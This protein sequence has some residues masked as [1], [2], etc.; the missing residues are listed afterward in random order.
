M[1]IGDWLFQ[2]LGI[3]FNYRPLSESENMILTLAFL[4]KV[5]ASDDD[6]DPEEIAEILKIARGNYERPIEEGLKTLVEASELSRKL[7]F[8]E[9]IEKA[10]DN[11]SLPQ[12]QEFLELVLEVVRVDGTVNHSENKFVASIVKGLGI[13]E[14]TVANAYSAVLKRS[15]EAKKLAD[16]G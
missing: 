15:I 16:K 8:E 14:D 1:N 7:S 4:I 6:S 2:K 3:S 11:F 5:S 12:K 9:A 13:S 10:N